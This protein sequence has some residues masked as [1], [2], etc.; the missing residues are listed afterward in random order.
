MNE[1]LAAA[2]AFVFVNVLQFHRALKW[3]NRKPCACEVCM[4]GWFALILDFGQ[5]WLT[6]PFKMALAMVMTIILTKVVKSI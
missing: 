1:L 3:M 6:V 4:G 2:G 5:Y